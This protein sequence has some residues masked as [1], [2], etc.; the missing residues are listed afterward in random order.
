MHERQVF[1]WINGN[2]PRPHG[3]DCGVWACQMVRELMAQRF[4][5]RLSLGLIDA[6][7]RGK[8]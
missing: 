6:V 1:R 3:F 4:G 5:A 2:N 7:L 8:D